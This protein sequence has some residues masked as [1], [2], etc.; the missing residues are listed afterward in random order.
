VKAAQENDLEATENDEIEQEIVD[1]DEEDEL[2][3]EAKLKNNAGRKRKNF[4]DGLSPKSEKRKFLELDQQIKVSTGSI[5]NS[6]LS[7]LIYSYY[8][9]SDP[10]MVDLWHENRLAKESRVYMEIGKNILEAKNSLNFNSPV[11]TA[12]LNV[13][14]QGIQRLILCFYI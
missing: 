14:T 13:A 7:F 11:N 9:E 3:F 1:S 12:I 4:S 10:L 6:F 5:I 8:V 2:E